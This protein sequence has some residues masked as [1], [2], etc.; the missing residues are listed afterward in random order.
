MKRPLVAMFC[1]F[2]LDAVHR[3][4]LLCPRGH[5]SKH[6]AVKEFEPQLL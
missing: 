6:L 1:P 2:V 4:D 3:T 5:S